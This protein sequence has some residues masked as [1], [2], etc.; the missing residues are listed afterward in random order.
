VCGIA[1]FWG[2]P[3]RSEEA[4]ALLRRMT[5]TI[6]HRGPDDEGQ[7]LDPAAGIALGHRRLSIIDLSPEG[8]QPMVSACGRYVIIF[9]GEIYNFQD[10]RDELLAQGAGPFRGHSDTEVMLAGIARWGLE[11]ALRRLAGMF[12]FALWDREQRTLA[13]VRDRL[14]EKPLYWGRAGATLLFGSELKALRTHPAFPAEID[15][16]ALALY[17]RYNYVPSPFCIYRGLQKVEP[18]SLCR[19]Y[20]DG[21]VQTERYWRLEEAVAAG[22]RAP[23]QGSD[24]EVL[25]EVE[26]ALQ[27]TVRQEMLSDV[28]LGAF[29]SGG[30]DSSTVVALMQRQSA[31]P[32]RT[33]TIGFHEPGYNEAE[34]AAA[35]AR[36]LGTDHTELYVTPEEARSVIPR[37]PEIYDE[38]FGDS[39]QIPTF[40]L[41]SLTRRQVTVALSGDGGDEMFSGYNRYVLGSRIWRRL[42]AVPGWM[43]RSAARGIRS[44]GP[45]RWE[46]WLGTAQRL[47]P[48]RARVAQVGDRMHKLAEV[49]PAASA[50]EMYRRMVSNWEQ[51]NDLVRRGT[52]PV[53]LLMAP[54]ALPEGLTFV[55]RMMYLDARTYLPDDIMVKVDR[56]AM[57]VSLESRAP[58][59]DHRIAELAWRLPLRFKLRGREGKWVLRRLLDRY[60]PRELL[61]RPKM[62]FG[63]PIDAWLRGPLRSWADALL[64]PARLERQGLLDPSLIR[65]RW[66]EHQSGRQNRQYPLWNVLMFQ[67]WL[68]G[69]PAS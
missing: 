10:L 2:P 3:F 35:V 61:A 9:N 57:A 12:A 44:V 39:S 23:L 21:R 41:S 8:H 67:A 59:L 40:L 32:V 65:R 26:R 6:R 33:F 13:L 60:V 18:A 5:D 4:S 20:P 22:A 53:T 34:H 69:Q 63:V 7:W 27:R 24:A 38:P 16:E 25:D 11:A 58:F 1:G 29:L 66:E 30:I 43:R 17:L 31:R 15:P 50:I 28:P 46:Q 64:D 51:P 56:A 36:H 55:E 68:E 37:L 62:G 14:G 42:S 47:L 49:I 52:E 45:D 54:Q 48:P 19:I